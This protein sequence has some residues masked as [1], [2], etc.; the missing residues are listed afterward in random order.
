MTGGEF[1]TLGDLA[2]I[3][4]F[5]KSL[6]SVVKL[7]VISQ[8][9]GQS[10]VSGFSAL[11]GELNRLKTGV[12]LGNFAIPIDNLLYPGMAVGALTTLDSYILEKTGS[13]LGFLYEDLVDDCVSSIH[14]QHEQQRENIQPELM[15][16][17]TLEA[18]ESHV[19]QRRQRE[20]TCPQHSSVYEIT[21]HDVSVDIAK[22]VTIHTL[23]GDRVQ[24]RQNQAFQLNTTTLHTFSSLFSRSSDVR[25]SIF[26]DAFTAAM[27]VLGFFMVPK[28]GFHYTFIP[29]AH[30]HVQRN[31]TLHRPHRSRIEGISLLVYSHRLNQ[32]Y[33][34]DASTFSVLGCH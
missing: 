25:T 20:K 6:S 8:K 15:V 28:A 32:V 2:F 7:P 33:G 9:I 29:P 1:D 26:W 10:F 24:A 34:W 4:T 12:Y 30:M 11:H 27:R 17:M 23:N 3:V 19:Q 16:P 14:K 18:S 5:L 21:P 31:I 22:K 13:K